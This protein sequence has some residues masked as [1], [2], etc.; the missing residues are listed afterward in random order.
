[1]VY[2]PSPEQ[3]QHLRLTST[4]LSFP[5]IPKKLQQTWLSSTSN[6]QVQRAAAVAACLLFS[7]A[8]ISFLRTPSTHSAAALNQHS[9]PAEL[10]SSS[11]CHKR[12]SSSS[13]A[14]LRTGNAAAGAGAAAGSDNGQQQQASSVWRRPALLLLGDSLTELGQVEDGGWSTKLTSAYVRKVSGNSSNSS[15]NNS[16][17]VHGDSSVFTKGV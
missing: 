2:A 14:R 17:R 9:W 16:S 15:S 1:M 11:S 4:P 10:S 3:K 5:V 8:V 12:S 13:K 6:S 7:L